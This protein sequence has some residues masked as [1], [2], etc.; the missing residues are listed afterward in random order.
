ML[1]LPEPLQDPL[2][3]RAKAVVFEDLGSRL[4]LEQIERIAPSD[5]PVLITGETGTGKELVA[6]QLHALSRRAAN[7]FVAINAGAFSEQ[8]IESELFGH[9]KGA[10]TG[11]TER[12]PGWFEAAQGGSLFLDEVG[13]LPLPLQVKLLR[14][15]QEREVMRVG[16]RSP[17]ALDVR[18]IA[19]TNVDLQS[20]IRA[21]QFREDLYY[22]LKVAALRLP[23]LRER[24]GDILPLAQHFLAMYQRRLARTGMSLGPAAAERLLV[25]PWPGTIRELENVI[26]HAV[27]V[28]RGPELGVHDLELGAASPPA[29]AAVPSRAERGGGELAE[30]ERVFEELLARGVPNLHERVQS[31][32]FGTAYRQCGENQLETARALGLSR[33]VVRARLIEGGELPGR[34]RRAPAARAL[35]R[36]GPKSGRVLRRIRIGYQ[37]L[38]LLMLVKARG[39][40]EAAF[41]ARDVAVEWREYAGGIQ[42]TEALAAS[43]L[44]IGIVGNSVAVFAQAAGVPIVYLAA[45]PP[46]PRGAAL[47]VPRGSKVQ[48]VH[49]LRGKR[50]AVNRAAQAH[51]LLLKAMEEAGLGAGE[52][53]I[54]FEPPASAFQSFVTG[55]VD[56]W[57]I[58]DPWLASARLEHGARVLRDATGLLENAS[59]YVAQRGFV[60]REPELVHEFVAELGAAAR[61]VAESPGQAL[62]SVALRCGLS[63]LALSASL[64]RELGTLPLD[65][66]LIAAQQDIADTLLRL[67]LIPRAVS[68]ADAQW[69]LRLAG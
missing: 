27:L 49:E 22:R 63:P 42:L 23:P 31:L 66:D 4:L 59:Y 56:A 44:D 38:G 24:P 46:A 19:A 54:V 62:E 34:V 33:H 43:Q 15:L 47:V 25:H 30:L 52:V 40:L 2:S 48:C 64:E 58:W 68:V 5:A 6:R 16:S 17:I 45:E 39:Q 69:P 13:D 50:V 26:H 11:A 20:A 60:E 53:E 55:A 1:T 51:Y 35:E 3:V 21:R 61:W 9:E 29:P 28:A 65:A 14:V 41:A 7:P 18:L 36:R 67:R 10:F 8:L 57:A 32:L 37:K 12:R